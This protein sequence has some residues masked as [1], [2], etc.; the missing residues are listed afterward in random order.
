MLVPMLRY[1]I[2]HSQVL[3]CTCSQSFNSMFDFHTL[4][5][6]ICILSCPQYIP[7]PLRSPFP[8]PSLPHPI[9]QEQQP[10]L[11]P[12]LT[13]PPTQAGLNL[14]LFG[15]L[16]GALSSKSQKST[17]KNPDGS[18]DTVESRAEQ[19]K[20]SPVYFLLSI[21]VRFSQTTPSLFSAS[22]AWHVLT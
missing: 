16:S 12:L 8:I 1:V 19:G 18:S 21:P 15:A 13:P 22:C 10:H 9:P 17:H 3:N 6:Y 11:S 4:P 20:P 5:F 7:V 14:N 2:T